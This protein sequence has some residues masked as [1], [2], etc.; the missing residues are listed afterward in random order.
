MA[1]A[2]SLAQSPNARR[3]GSHTLTC[4]VCQGQRDVSYETFQRIRTGKLSGVC[5]RCPG[6]PREVRVRE[7]DRKFWLRRY[8]VPASELRGVSAV[9]YVAAHGLPAELSAL[10]ASVAVALPPR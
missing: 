9:E 2:A 6:E 10:A 1:V 8:G 4:P 7:Q 3:T 5:A